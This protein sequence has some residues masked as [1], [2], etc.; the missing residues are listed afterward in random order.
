MLSVLLDEKEATHRKAKREEFL[1][2]Q[3]KDKRSRSERGVHSP[4][5]QGSA[6]VTPGFDYSNQG[7]NVRRN[8]ET[9]GYG[10][11]YLKPFRTRRIGP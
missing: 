9:E 1:V 5:Q 2:R 10:E 8:I 7:F 6:S 3:R 4:Y 11:A